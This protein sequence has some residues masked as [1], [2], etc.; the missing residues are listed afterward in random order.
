MEII[1]SEEQLPNE[2]ITKLM[3]QAGALCGER[4]GL[5]PD[6]LSVSVTFV[7]REE[8][9][10]LNSMYRG[11][12]Q[13]TDVLSFPQYED[14]SQA[15]DEDLI[16][17]GDVVICTQEALLQADEYGH[18]PQRELVYLFVHSMFHLLGYDHTEEEDTAAMRQAEEEI[19]DKLALAR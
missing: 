7:G 15:E 3:E 14:L 1:F 6:K 5:S 9:K 10:E 18:S 4:E 17:L 16:C 8:I 19:M 13:V 12:D 11:I 2:E